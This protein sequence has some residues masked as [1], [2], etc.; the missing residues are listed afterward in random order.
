L[1]NDWTSRF[2]RYKAE[3]TDLFDQLDRME[4]HRLPKGWDKDLTPFPADPKGMATRVSSGKVLNAIA[5]NVPWLLGGSADLAP[6]TKTTLT[7]PGAGVFQAESYGGR[8]FHF[9]VRE[10]AMGGILNGMAV[11]KVRPF[12]A[13]FLI[14][15]DYGRAPIRLAAL[16]QFP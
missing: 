11:T 7:F 10:H 3:H 4:R 13:G 8:N 15:S 5:K 14:F 16:S 1:H 6:S 9:G 2:E 12:G